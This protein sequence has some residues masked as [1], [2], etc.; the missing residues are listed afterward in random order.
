M[1]QTMDRAKK[2]LRGFI[3]IGALFGLLSSLPLIIKYGLW[4]GLMGT[5]IG[6]VLWTAIM[7]II[8]IPID[9]IL[10]RKLPAEALGV[11]QERSVQVKEGVT[12]V[13]EKSIAIL[14]EFK[15]IKQ[16]DFA[17]ESQ[18]ITARTKASIASFGENITLQFK[19]LNADTTEIHISSCPLVRHTVLDFGKNFRNVEYVTK[20]ITGS[21]R[22][23]KSDSS[24][25]IPS[26]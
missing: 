20:A 18:N 16:I 13:F 25:M 26:A 9:Y 7:A 1:E 8:F 12:Q 21:S 3:V 23:D 15:S 6:T 22:M 14:K 24:T 11:Q 17:K 2:Y 19:P 5:L 10:T 4:Q